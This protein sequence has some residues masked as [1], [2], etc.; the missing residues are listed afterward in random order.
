MTKILAYLARF[1]AF[2]LMGLADI[3]DERNDHL[4]GWGLGLL[5]QGRGLMRA[6][7]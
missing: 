3:P 4:W 1:I 6:R 5:L 7:K 2:T